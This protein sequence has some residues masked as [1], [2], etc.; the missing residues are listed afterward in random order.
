MQITIIGLGLIGGSIARDLSTAWPHAVLTGVDGNN[1]HAETALGLKLVHK[2]APLAE[3]V[4][5]ADLVILA[6]PVDAIVNILP[7]V[8]DNINEV[9]C[10]TD[11]GSTKMAIINSVKSHLNRKRFV[12]AH[13]M[14]GTENSGP[15]AA[16]NNLFKNRVAII[17]NR[18]ESASDALRTAELLFK[19]ALGMRM[20]YM[21]AGAHDEQAAFI[22]HLPHTISYALVLAALAVSDKNGNFFELAGG[23]FNSMA[24]LARSAAP[25]WEPIFCQNSKNLLE[26]I[27]AFQKKLSD[28]RDAVA[29][30]DAVRLRELISAANRIRQILP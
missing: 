6:I 24:R 21:D 27:D 10:V 14:A 5:Q 20:V 4:Q 19:Q 28:F 25:M 16:M 26:A 30:Q 1:Q 12:A 22:S 7:D 29:Q 13:P 3:A 9:A 23:G 17:C 11:M 8:L 2:V 18:E 15:A